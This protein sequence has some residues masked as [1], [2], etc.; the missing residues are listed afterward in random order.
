LL[1]RRTASEAVVHELR[2]E[3]Q[4]GRLQPGQRLRQGEVAKRFGVS[5]T[6][7]REAFALLQAQGLVRID[8]HR[9]AIVFRAAAG[10]LR[11]LYEIREALEVLAI[12]RAT[13]HLTRGTLDELQ[14]FID[15]MRVT[16][17]DQRWIQ[18]NNRFHATT[19]RAAA[20]PRLET[21]IGT[22]R[23]AS[24]SYIHMYITHRPTADR[25]KNIRTSWMR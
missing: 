7:V 25:I 13:G 11:E 20:K 15:K 24:S 2:S 9:G 3:I 22:L 21:M 19:Y 8:P 17:E 12:E 1:A 4:R 6:P 23:D 10:D 18:L 16:D 14:G 5:T